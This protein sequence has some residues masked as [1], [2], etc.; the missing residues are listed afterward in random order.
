MVNAE[1]ELS[2]VFGAP[3]TEGVFGGAASRERQARIKYWRKPDGWIE[4]GPHVSTSPAKYQAFVEVKR[5]RE[6]PDSFGREVMGAKGSRMFPPNGF[7]RGQEHHWLLPFFEAGGHTYVC[8]ATDS[9]GAAGEP[10]MPMAQLVSL[11]LHRNEDMVKVR[12]DL[13][14]AVD[15]PCPY[16]CVNERTRRPRVFGGCTQEEAEGSRDQHIVAVHKDAVASRAV[17]DTIANALA[18]NAGQ[19][20]NP[21]L[22]ASIVAAVS[23]AMRGPEAGAVAAVAIEN[24]I[25][26]PEERKY[27]PAPMWKM[28]DP[29]EE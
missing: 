19:Q 7:P 1:A 4:R 13:A 8:K 14:M 10:L 18:N 12:P 24:K 17:G 23:A 25:V 20:I 9:F 5:W 16:G 11:G 27:G 6:L 28:P 15:A 29:T 22:I 21:E 26:I 3:D 2:S